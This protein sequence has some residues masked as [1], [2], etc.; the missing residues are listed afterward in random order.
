MLQS[1]D[2]LVVARLMAKVFEK[3]RQLKQ[4]KLTIR[5]EQINELYDVVSE[6]VIGYRRNNMGFLR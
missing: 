3:Q 1:K 6:S 2:Y 5:A 4:N